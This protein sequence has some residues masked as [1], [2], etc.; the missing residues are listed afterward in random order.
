[1]SAEI[2]FFSITSEVRN[3]LTVKGSKFIALAAPAGDKEQ[4]ETYIAAVSQ[5]FHD[6]THHCFAYKIG[7]GDGAL[8]RFSDA[9]EPSGTAGR[10]I[11]QAIES[12]KLANL[13]V[14]VTRYFGGTK[15]GTGGLIR[16][17]HAAALAALHQAEVVRFYPH[18]KLRVVFPFQFA[19]T[20][21]RLL[22]KFRGQ[23]VESHFAEQSEYVIEIKAVDAETFAAELRES[24]SGRV[25]V[26]IQ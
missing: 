25:S 5:K 2:D 8:F 20:V 1:M 17:Y 23:V 15:L 14:V 3:E 21:H 6:A 19:N 7:V 26:R 16:A 4:A 9:G 24:T 18:I 13:V 12:Q 10:P 11:L 22:H